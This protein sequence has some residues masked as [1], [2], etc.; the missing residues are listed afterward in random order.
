MF[1]KPRFF[2]WDAGSPEIHRQSVR[3]LAGNAKTYIQL[4][5]E[6]PMYLFLLC[7]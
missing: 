6:M 4:T 5:F 7:T 2:K 1:S 3:F